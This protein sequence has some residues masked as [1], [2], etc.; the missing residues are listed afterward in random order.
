MK[1]MFASLLGIT[2]LCFAVKSMAF[3][4]PTGGSSAANKAKA[5]TTEVAKKGIEKGLNDKLSKEACT[6]ANDAGEE[7]SDIQCKSGTID[8]VINYVNDW[9]NGLEGT[10]SSDFNLTVTV[11]GKS[12]VI[13]SRTG[14]L[15]RKVDSKM[16]Y[17]D[18]IVR[19]GGDSDNNVGLKVQVK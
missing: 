8:T 7:P 17:W 12:E 13:S 11:N 1:K 6:Y 15:Q 14:S 4:I 5:V 2:V 10:I 16:N 3:D 18:N 19:S 9:H